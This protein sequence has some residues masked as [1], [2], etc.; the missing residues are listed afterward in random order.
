MADVFIFYAR[1][2]VECA[3]ALARMVEAD[4]HSV[5]YDERLPAHRTYADVIQEQLDL[6]KAVLIIWSREA[7]RSQ[8]VRSEA[9]R[10]RV[11]GTLIQMRI[12]DCVLPMPFDRIECPVVES[13]NADRDHGQTIGLRHRGPVAGT[14]KLVK[15]QWQQ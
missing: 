15:P 7:A 11:N 9:D 14:V 5:W 6:A 3:E 10:A 12:D 2:T 8:W 13:L 4:G 1:S